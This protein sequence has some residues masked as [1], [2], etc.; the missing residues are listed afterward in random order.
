MSTV[1]NIGET[2]IIWVDK[3]NLLLPELVELLKTFGDLLPDPLSSRL[4]LSTYA[5][6]IQ[7]KAEIALAYNSKKVVG[8]LMMYANDFVS[9]KAHIPIISVLSNFRG[10]GIGKVLLS[11][12]VALARQKKMHELWLT[13]DQ[14]NQVAR[15]VYSEL[16]FVKIDIDKTKVIMSRNLVPNRLLLD[17]QVTPLESGHTLAAMLGLDIDLWIKRDDLYPIAGGGIKAR[18]IG[19][20][21]KKAIEDGHDVIVTNGGP[22]S[23]HARAAAILAANLGIKC[24]LVI[25]LESGQKYLNSGNILLMKLSGA[26][27]EYTTKDLLASR[28]N[29]AIDR[30]SHM[31]HNPLYIWGG[32]H[33]FQGTVAFVDAAI[34]A[35]QQCGNWKPDYLV[36][37]SGTGTTQAGLAI[38]YGS[39]NTQVIG[40][41]VA[42]DSKRGT[43]II[44]ECIEDYYLQ[45]GRIKQEIAIHFLDDWV[46]GGYEKYNDELFSSIEKAAKAGYFFDPTYSGKALLGLISLIQTGKIPE[47][48]NVL[49]W[50]T[51]GLMNLQAVTHY[52][53]RT[54]QL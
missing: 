5:E 34:E 48:S 36:M 23:N 24:H 3:S 32:G 41:S 10:H 30:F 40:I 27:I 9:R 44:R 8:F 7:E 38:G 4:N 42:R 17:P 14:E 46:C 20:I 54:F 31:G 33:C 18:K 51:G 43:Q 13:V 22:Q 35:Q 45:A 21:I 29:E 47:R 25:V 19:Y 15:H 16:G 52:S 1:M 50:H 37:A 39:S 49:L 11:R 6:K 12:A 53:E 2:I 26:S 28:M